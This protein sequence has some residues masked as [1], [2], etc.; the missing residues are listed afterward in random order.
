MENEFATRNTDTYYG[1]YINKDKIITFDSILLE[2]EDVRSQIQDLIDA[3][4]VENY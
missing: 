2:D 4:L 1:I 3:G